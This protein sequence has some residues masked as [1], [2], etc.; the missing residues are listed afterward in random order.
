[1][2]R[3]RTRPYLALVLARDDVA[4]GDPM[5]A[6]KLYRLEEAAASCGRSYQAFRADISRGLIRVVRVGRRG[7]RIT[8][9]ELARLRRS[10]E[11]RQG[12]A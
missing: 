6:P 10:A 1:M 8:E 12:A 7:I 2:T 4:Q 9:E 5:E 11:P 3:G